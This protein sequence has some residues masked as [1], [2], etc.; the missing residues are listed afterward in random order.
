MLESCK[1]HTVEASLV[2]SESTV[3][4][5]TLPLNME[6]P[7]LSVMMSS[8]TETFFYGNS[9]HILIINGIK[10]THHPRHSIR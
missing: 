5:G 7:F 6:V 10:Y 2:C 3:I 1:R 4:K 9:F 8:Y